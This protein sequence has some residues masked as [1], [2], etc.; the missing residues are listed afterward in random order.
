MVPICLLFLLHPTPPSTNTI[1]LHLFHSFPIL[2]LLYQM[3]AL[4]VVI[5][6]Y[7]LQYLHVC[8]SKSLP[9]GLH[10]ALSTVT[11]NTNTYYLVCDLCRN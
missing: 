5:H 10:T 4:R 11:G 3:Y 8:E 7:C 2:S 1:L 6:I 9:P